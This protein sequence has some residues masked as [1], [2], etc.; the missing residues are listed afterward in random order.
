MSYGAIFPLW[1]AAAGQTWDDYTRHAFVKGLGNG[2][3]PREAFLRYLVQDY[4]FLIHFSRAWALAVTKAETP[5]EMRACAATVH[6]LLDG[7]LQLH[8]ETCAA[9]GISE[10]QL[11]AAREAPQNLAYTRYVLDAGH[12]GDFLDLM[13]ALAVCVLG[14]GEIGTRLA[15][16]AGE[17][18]YAD[19]IATYAGAEY[20]HTCREVGA[21]IDAATARRLGEQPESSPRWPRLCARFEMATRLE[22]DFWGMGLSA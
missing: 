15:A 10:A 20:Q 1:R 12:S 5:E 3:L 21:L 8:I 17:T 2:T 14:Y 13:A 11:F 16:Q 22:V 7:E 19:W 18:P 4:L 9:E 6:A